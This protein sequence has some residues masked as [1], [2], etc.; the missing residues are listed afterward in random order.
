[1]REDGNGRAPPIV[2]HV[3]VMDHGSHD[4]LPC[5]TCPKRQISGVV[6]CGKHG[7]CEEE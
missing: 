4:K 1:M 2:K 3:L 6:S 5:P 7:A